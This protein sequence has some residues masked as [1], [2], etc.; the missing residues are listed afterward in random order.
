MFTL[1]RVLVLEQRRPVELRQPVRILREMA[2]HPVEN[3]PDSVDVARIDERLE[4]LPLAEPARRGE[5][6]DHLVAPGPREWMLHHREQLNMRIAHLLDIRN[7]LLGKLPVGQVSVRLFR[8][9]RPR[10]QVYLVD[11]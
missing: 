11:G 6:P 4:L 1:A 7:E 8:D 10:S 3:D 2:R 9:P 5:E